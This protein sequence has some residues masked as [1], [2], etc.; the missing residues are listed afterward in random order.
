M[1]TTAIARMRSLLR[2]AGDVICKQKKENHP[3]KKAQGKNDFK[4]IRLIKSNYNFK[5]TDKK[6]ILSFSQKKC[7]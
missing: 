6:V 4:I 2:V 1:A 5:S 3:F 7:N